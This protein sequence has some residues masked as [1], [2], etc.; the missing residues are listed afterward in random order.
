M[1]LAA[2]DPSL[3]VEASNTMQSMIDS[4]LAQPRFL[5]VILAIFAA[6]ALGLT[7][8]GILGVIAYLVLAR[9]Y[10]FGVRMALGAQPQDVL[11]LICGYGGRLAAAGIAL[12][13]GGS[14]ALTRL[15]ASYLYGVKPADPATLAVVAILVLSAAMLACY[16]PARRAMRIDPAR[17]LRHD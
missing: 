11:A 16:A 3:V 1:E 17:A 9:T 7:V 5:T 12:G 10:E 15:L 4:Q 13:I 6:L 8:T 14:L 2:I